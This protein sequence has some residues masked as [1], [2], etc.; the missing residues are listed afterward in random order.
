MHDVVLAVLKAALKWEQQ[1]T[2]TMQ[3][4]GEYK[5]MGPEELA[6]YEAVCAYRAALGGLESALRG[7]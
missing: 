7:R 3:Y 1:M 4:A 5:R 6:L 2:A